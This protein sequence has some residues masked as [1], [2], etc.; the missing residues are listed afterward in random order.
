MGF[1]EIGPEVACGL[2]RAKR[3]GLVALHFRQPFHR[4]LPQHQRGV[5]QGFGSA[6]QDQVAAAVGDV[7]IGRVHR[8][9]AGAAIDLHG[10][11]GGL[12]AA[13]KAQGGD[14]GRVRLVRDDVHAAQ[15]HLIEGR[16]REWLAQQQRP[17]A[18]HGQIDRREGT[19]AAACLQERGAGTVDDI[20]RAA[21]SAGSAMRGVAVSWRTGRGLRPRSRP[22]RS[23]PPRPHR[24]RA[25]SPVPHR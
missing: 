12:R 25:S 24:R 14:A 5:A 2:E 16:R 10:E 7:A 9:H 17:P 4:V 13:A 8:L 11:G 20:D 15:D 3:A 19:G 22:P 18:L 1:Q 23:L 6:C 21:H